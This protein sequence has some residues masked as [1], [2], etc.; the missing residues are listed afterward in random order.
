M[1]RN[2]VVAL[3][4]EAGLLK[5]ELAIGSEGCNCYSWGVWS[6]AA[7]GSGSQSSSEEP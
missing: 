6:R 2:D 1:P 4:G 5:S 7:C 3:D